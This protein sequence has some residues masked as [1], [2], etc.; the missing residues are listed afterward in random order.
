ME[1]AI[2]NSSGNQREQ[3][4]RLLDNPWLLSLPCLITL[5][6]VFAYHTFPLGLS[7]FW[8][9]LNTGRWIWNNAAL[10][11]ADPF[12]FSSP[13]PLDARATLILRGYPLSQLLM[14]GIYKV[15]GIAGLVALK[16]VLMTLFYVLL[17]DCLRRN[18]LQ[19]FLALAVVGLLPLLFF[20]FDELRPQVFSFIGTLLVMQLAENLLARGRRGER[21]HWH[22]LA[23]LPLILL[24]WANLHRGYIIGVGML[25]V[26]L[27]AETVR[28]RRGADPLPDEAYRRFLVAVLVSSGISFINPVGVT[29]MWAS[30]TEV[31]GPFSKVIDEFFGTLKYFEFHGMELTGYL[32][33]AAAV[34]P[35]IALLAKWRQVSLAHVLMLAAFLGAGILSFRFSLMMVAAVLVI[36]SIYL[37]PAISRWLSMARGLPLIVIWGISAAMLASSAY[38]RTSLFSSPLENGVIPSAAVDYLARTG[39][40]GNIYNPF[41]YG[42]YLSWRLYPQKIFIDQRNLSWDVYE[43]YSR[44]WRGDYADVFRKYRIG[45]VFYPLNDG[46]TNGVSRLVAGLLDNPQWEVGYYDGVDIILFRP[47]LNRQVP[48]MNRQAVI[49]D[50]VQR[51]RR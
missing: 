17:W 4:G 1:T 35:A 14:L 30:F 5:A 21:L 45:V 13:I 47:E 50:I 49:S 16:A 46:S 15:G 27:L 25:F 42:G 23:A 6:G 48:F 9:H 7:D 34:I 33:V 24:L 37:A 31:A 51:F 43:E 20:R 19:P 10:P 41:E 12:L 44:V 8:W 39:L 22:A 26:Y 36:A 11:T 28:R 3:R 38:S 32:I 29:A 40:N 2:T 18:G